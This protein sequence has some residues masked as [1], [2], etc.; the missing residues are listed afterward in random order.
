MQALGV[1]HKI[2]NMFELEGTSLT[3]TMTEQLLSQV[4]VINNE[5]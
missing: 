4:S 3:Q 1:T 2:K 5:G